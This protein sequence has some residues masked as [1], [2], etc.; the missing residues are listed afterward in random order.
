MFQIISAYLE[1]TKIRVNA[2]VLFTTLAGFLLAAGSEISWL[3]LWHTLFGTLLIAG[4]ACGINECWERELDARMPRTQT[5][6]L[7]EK[8]LSV[9][10]AWTFSFGLSFA[11]A[12]YLFLFVNTLTAA[13]AVIT[14]V[15]YA[16]LYT[17][18]KRKSSAAT[19][20]GAISGAIPPMMGWSAVK[21][22]LEI[23][24][25]ILFFI[26]FFWQI[27]AFLS[28]AWIYRADYSKAQF[29][30]LTVLD[31]EKA[32]LTSSQILLFTGALFW[33]SLFP[34]FMGLT[35]WL[36][37]SG[38]IILGALLFLF[39]YFFSTSEKEKE[40][41]ARRVFLTAMLY[42]PIVLTLLVIDVNWF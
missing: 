35:Y 24:A 31:T 1:L 5:R 22:N 34:A 38:A 15:I 30:M 19:L 40:K 17:P 2:L 16:F 18:F 7:P 25:W 20:V 23:E 28:I 6:P 36:Y 14:L 42:L 37:L 41:Y 11:G 29:P 3:L 26:L 8:R 33:V 39:G 32:G 27:P 12:G 10:H 4:G 9:A 13:L 21:N